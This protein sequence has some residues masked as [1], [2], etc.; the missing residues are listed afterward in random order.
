MAD[1]DRDSLLHLAELARIELDPEEE[2]GL[3]SDLKKI[4]AHFEELKGL[5]TSHV[6]PMTGGTHLKNVFRDDTATDSTNHGQG[7][8]NFPD[9]H[10]GFLKVPPVFE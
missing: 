7:I 8:Q 4:L 1:I 9:S 5:D 2:S 10:K 6:E 3:V